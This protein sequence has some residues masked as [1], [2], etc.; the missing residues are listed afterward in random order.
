MKKYLI[1]IG[2]IIIF[3]GLLYSA[4][5]L[6]KETSE[7]T[8]KEDVAVIVEEKKE[9]IPTENII[10]LK[11]SLLSESPVVWYSPF[12]FT[13]TP[14]TT[15]IDTLSPSATDQN[16]LS[17]S[18]SLPISDFTL[19]PSGRFSLIEL[20]NSPIHTL[21]VFDR[22]TNSLIS[23][24]ATPISAAFIPGSDTEVFVLEKNIG[25]KRV[26]LEKKTEKILLSL[27]LV[28]A[29]ITPLSVS[30]ILVSEKAD[31]DTKEKTFLV[32]TVNQTVTL[33]NEAP[34]SL[35]KNI[36]AF[37]LEYKEADNTPELILKDSITK[38]EIIN[39]KNALGG[40][41][42][43]TLPSKCAGKDALVICAFP[44]EVI[45]K[46]NFSNRYTRGEEYPRDDLYSFEIRKGE[47]IVKRHL[48]F[49]STDSESY[50]FKNLFIL[51]S[52]LYFINHQT[53]LLHSLPL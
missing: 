53:D 38:K 6:T 5:L 43:F 49:S 1:S 39:F 4:Y 36:N 14:G 44:Q 18:R 34:V 3:L 13:S 15:T 21:T 20:G 10:K 23:L 27:D 41:N 7:N 52:T 9:A 2:F 30:E 22:K 8:S 16:I 19:S 31:P 12:S 51:N 46:N 45:N 25:I 24:G 48:I 28:E 33:I 40:E 17:L 11:A 50:Q 42:N 32:N 35:Y 47:G 29:D 26:N 37:Y